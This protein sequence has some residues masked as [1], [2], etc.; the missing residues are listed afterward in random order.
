M[1][2]KQ[3]STRELVRGGKAKKG[4]EPEPREVT[5]TIANIREKPPEKAPGEAAAVPFP[6]LEEP[7]KPAM[8]TGPAEKA[9]PNKKQSRAR[10]KKREKKQSEKKSGEWM[11]DKKFWGVSSLVLA[12]ILA[13]VAM[14]LMERAASSTT[15]VLVVTSD[16]RAGT[17]LSRDMVEL[18]QMGGYDFP[19]AV[20]DNPDEAVGKYTAIDLQA[21]DVLTSAKV[22]DS[23]IQTDAYLY[24]LPEGKMAMSVSLPELADSVSGKLRSGDIIRLFAVADGT[25]NDTNAA[26]TMIPEL[27]YVEVLAVTNSKVEDINDAGGAEQTQEEKNIATVTLLVNN[28]QAE[29]LAGLNSGATLHAALVTRGD[30]ETKTAALEAQDRYFAE[31]G[32]ASN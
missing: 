15:P 8:E 22:T 9:L 5:I 26:A 16:V 25:T 18:R 20:L 13:F 11:K 1:F 6:S 2:G 24:N 31:N 29:A 23:Y 30:P 10:Q 3:K 32:G 12:L 14:P 28:R 7:A 4:P 17:V 19:N 27:Q 21:G